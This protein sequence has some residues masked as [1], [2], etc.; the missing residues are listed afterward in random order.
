MTDIN[1]KFK[2][3]NC[4]GP[5]PPFPPSRSFLDN[6]KRTFQNVLINVVAVVASPILIYI[7]SKSWDN[8]KTIIRNGRKKSIKDS[9]EFKN[10]DLLRKIWTHPV[11]KLYFDA[12]EYQRMEGWCC[13]TTI[14][15]V[16][17]SIP[18]IKAHQI[19]EAKRGPATVSEF[20]AKIDG[21]SRSKFI[22][23]TTML[24]SD[25]YEKFLAVIKEKV[26]DPKYRVT[27]N[28]LRSSLFGFKKPSWL[29]INAVLGNAMTT[30]NFTKN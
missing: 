23:S 15:S 14:R 11:G 24:G 1:N 3:T 4:T 9:K 12:V 10:E 13:A 7:F 17:K 2:D 25:G 22:K 6:I 20:A 28:F 30:F 26:N 16:L 18:A 21:D 19:P 29:P 27:V 8:V 5:S